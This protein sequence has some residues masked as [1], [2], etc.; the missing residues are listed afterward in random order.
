MNK[1]RKGFIILELVAAILIVIVGGLSV[2][3]FYCVGVR[4]MLRHNYTHEAFGLAQAT[5]LELR[6]N[7]A[8]EQ[9]DKQQENFRIRGG[10]IPV[11]TNSNYKILFVEVYLMGET[12]P[13]VN[14]V[15]YD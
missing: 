10:K 6:G 4:I 13:V 5:L 1:E 8:V 14:L 2:V 9:V 15:G 11:G 3:S 12:I 7:T